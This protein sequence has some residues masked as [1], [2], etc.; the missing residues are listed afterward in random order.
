MVDRGRMRDVRGARNPHAK[1]T[2][3]D[4]RQIRA[5]YASGVTQQE[6][7]DMFNVQQAHVSRVVRRETWAEV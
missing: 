6:L 4:V 3:E 7:A 5:G 2:P 1:L